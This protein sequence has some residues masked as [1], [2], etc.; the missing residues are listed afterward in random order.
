VQDPYRHYPDGPGAIE[1]KEDIKDLSNAEGRVVRGGSFLSQALDV[2]S[3]YR[4]NGRPDDRGGNV[5][6][7]VARTY[8]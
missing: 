3:A 7:R 5:G 1:D 2:R 4:G 8:R 6:L